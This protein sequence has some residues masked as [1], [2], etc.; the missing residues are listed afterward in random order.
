MQEVAPG[1]GRVFLKVPS[2]IILTKL[3][4]ER[5]ALNPDLIL[6]VDDGR[7]TIV[8][9]VDG[10]TYSVAENVDV[11]AD[12]MLSYRICLVHGH[13]ADDGKRLRAVRSTEP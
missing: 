1:A 3:S 5:F 7:D 13:R 9:M 11:V 2:V 4:G 10:S 6:S 8:T 12:R